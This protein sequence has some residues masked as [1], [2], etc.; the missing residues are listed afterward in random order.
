MENSTQKLGLWLELGL[1][2]GLE[3]GLGI[4]LVLVLELGTESSSGL[5]FGF[6]PTEPNLWNLPL[7]FFTISRNFET[8]GCLYKVG[9][10]FLF[11]LMTA[12]ISIGLASGC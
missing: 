7:L 4:G 3:L 8:L 6:G 2:I 1:G 10:T 5:G 12:F 11:D 9:R